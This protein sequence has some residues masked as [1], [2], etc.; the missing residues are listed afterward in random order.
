MADQSIIRITKV[1]MLPLPLPLPLSLPIPH[2]PGVGCTE[3]EPLRTLYGRP[4]SLFSRVA[5]LTASL[6][7]VGAQR[8]PEECR[9]LYAPILPTL[10]KLL[11]VALTWPHISF[12][13][14][15]SRCRCS[16]RQGRDNRP[17]RDPIRVRLLRGWCS[18]H[19]TASY[20]CVTGD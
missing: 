10:S 11:S 12:G 15:L 20:N 14:C 3:A 4:S 7:N 9:P 2:D 5:M 17:P 19:T 6:G 16:Q 13:R 1:C 18:H 8:T